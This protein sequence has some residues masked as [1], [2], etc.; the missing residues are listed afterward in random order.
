M[1]LIAELAVRLSTGPAPVHDMH[2]AA[3]ADC[4]LLA[5]LGIV[6]L[7]LAT[8]A[9]EFARIRYP[10][11]EALRSAPVT[12]NPR[13]EVVPV[14]IAA[15]SFVPAK[16]RP[17]LSVD[18]E[19]YFQ[20]EAM[21]QAGHR[22]SWEQY[23]LRV[24]DNTRRLLDLF[25]ESGAKG[26]FFTMG[27]IADKVPFLIREIADRGHE[28]ACHSY[29]HRTIYSL[30]PE[31]FR[32][33]TRNAIT[34]IEDAAGVR[35]RGYRA[36][37]WSIT[38]Q[39]LWA[40]QILAEEGFWYDSSIYPIHHDLY[41]IP[42]AMP[43]PHVWKFGNS[44]ILEIPPATYAFGEH[45]L[46]AA[47]GGYLRIFPL[48]FSRMA[49]DQL[50]GNHALPVVYMHPWEIDP[51]QPRLDAPLKARIRQYWGLSSFEG[52]LRRLLNAYE[53]VPFRDRW[54]EVSSRA[55]KVHIEIP[56]MA[57]AS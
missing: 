10:E 47:G 12:E 33:D 57:V 45:R 31:E 54:V 14:E 5:I 8:L 38:R 46:P 32:S 22:K 34:A 18:V 6:F 42:Q 52:K 20:T 26:T 44:E 7:L 11:D 41:G 19:D 37:T 1:I 35:V 17:L 13:F 43:T 39:S 3:R 4:L 29:W 36:P 40:V 49:I 23:P 27:W 28:L 50:T 53:F 51:G 55:P 30:S 21:S 16:P 9:R 56:E 48:R 25:D 15:Q 24:V 2:A